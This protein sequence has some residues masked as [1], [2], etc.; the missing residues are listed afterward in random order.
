[1]DNRKKLPFN[2]Y[3]IGFMGCGKSSAASYLNK[4]YGM[5]LIEMD[6]TIVEEAGM[7][8]S[9]IF[10]EQ[11]EAA[12]RK[13]ETDL[14]KRMQSVEN[15]VISCGGGVPMREENVRLMKESGKIVLLTASPEVILERVGSSSH[16]PLLEGRKT[17]EGIAELMD[18]R[19]PAYEAAADLTIM[20]DHKKNKEVCE[21][22]L[23]RLEAE[24]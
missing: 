12:F 1:M 16:R 10:E 21:E 23:A 9:R 20:T 5:P 24:M 13:M 22:I 11:G 15:T 19:R 17:V 7:P 8:I 4:K 18:A 14:L 3:L 6:E 2:I